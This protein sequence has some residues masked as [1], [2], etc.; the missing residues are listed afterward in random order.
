MIELVSNMGLPIDYFETFGLPPQDVYVIRCNDINVGVVKYCKDLKSDDILYIKYIGIYETY[1]RQGIATKVIEL[2]VKENQDKYIC[3]DSDPKAIKFWESIGV[4]F[5]EE[6]SDC[7]TT[8]F[9]I[10]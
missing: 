4:E 3:G 8:P 9:Y 5:E 10:L 1:R 6:I 7:S 2:I